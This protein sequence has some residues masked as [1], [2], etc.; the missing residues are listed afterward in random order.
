MKIN[1]K[2]CPGCET[3]KSVDNFHNN[4]RTKSGKSSWCKSCCKKYQQSEKGKEVQKKSIKKW[5]ENNPEKHKEI[6]KANNQLQKGKD[7]RK[8]YRQSEKDKIARKEYRQT[9]SYKEGRERY[10]QSDEGKEV[11]KRSSKKRQENGKLAL[12]E[13]NKRLIDLNYQLSQNLRGRIW[14]ALKGKSKSARTLELIGCSLEFFKQ[15]LENQFKDEMSWDNFG[16]LKAEENNYSD[17]WDVDHYVPC[18]FFNLSDSTEQMICFHWTN[19]QPL[20]HKD[21]IKKRN[22]LPPEIKELLNIAA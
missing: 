4:S 17:W 9:K 13:H 8:I 12:Y 16:K 1:F 11:N 7:A 3:D 10:R 6:Q 19:L 20:W 18:N 2:Y 14:S 5:I 15:H 22:H 21:N